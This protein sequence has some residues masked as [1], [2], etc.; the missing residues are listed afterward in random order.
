MPRYRDKWKKNPGPPRLTKEFGREE[1]SGILKREEFD[2]LYNPS[3]RP[4]PG[5]KKKMTKAVA[6]ALLDH[7]IEDI[8]EGLGAGSVL[9]AMFSLRDADKIW[10][11]MTESLRS[12]YQRT[13][14][15]ADKDVRSA[16]HRISARERNRISKTMMGM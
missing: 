12:K 3:Y 14:A 4:N 9:I 7:H 10:R 15:K 6:V 16:F 2:V 13:L 8:Y 5:P 1:L 11:T